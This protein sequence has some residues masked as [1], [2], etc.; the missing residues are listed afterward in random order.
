MRYSEILKLTSAD[1]DYVHGVITLHETKNGEIRSI[2][3]MGAPLEM[4]KELI[5]AISHSSGL[6]FPS[7]NDPKKPIDIRSAWDRAVREADIPKFRFHDLR[8]TTASYLAMGGHSLLDIATLLGHKDL[9]MTK[10]YSH[11]SQEYKKQ[12]V[13]TMTQ[14]IME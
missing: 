4:V 13:S 12:M 3:L 11:L 14:K 5:Q 7:P 9:Q 10:R 8:H 6:L 1:I 2:P